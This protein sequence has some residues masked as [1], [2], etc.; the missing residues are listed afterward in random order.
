[1]STTTPRGDRT[2]APPRAPWHRRHRRVVGLASAAVA[3]GMTALWVAVVPDRA[4]TTTGLQS[5]AIRYGHPASWACLAAVGVAFAAAG[6]RWLR[7]T[8]AWSALGAY[9]A[10]LLALLL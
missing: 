8:L 10:F 6:P 9:V 4:A 2:E 5:W 3:L 1:M 7:E